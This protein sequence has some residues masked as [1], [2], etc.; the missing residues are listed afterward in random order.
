MNNVPITTLL[1]DGSL[2]CGFNVAIKWL[3]AWSHVCWIAH[4]FVQV[5][6]NILLIVL[7]SIALRESKP[8]PKHLTSTKVIQDLNLDFR[9]DPDPDPCVHQ[10]AP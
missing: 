9:I 8:L 7:Y 3:M 1:Y 2:L 4:T 6:I 5:V 10:I